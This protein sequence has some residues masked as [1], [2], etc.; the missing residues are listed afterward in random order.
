M[1]LVK[2]WHNGCTKCFIREC[3]KEVLLVMQTA[4]EDLVSSFKA[5][6]DDA[7]ELLRA[8]ANDASEKVATSR[9]R[10]ER[11]LEEGKKTLADAQVYLS[12]KT[13][14]ATDVAETYMKEYPWSAV[15]IAVGVGLVLG[16]L[17]RRN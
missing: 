1:E 5:L 9:R 2:F 6:L 16:L 10:I 4:R 17:S 3:R 14:E 8:T 13:K 12:E 15:G 7:E 11:R